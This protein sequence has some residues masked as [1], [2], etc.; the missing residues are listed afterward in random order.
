MTD[1]HA[2]TLA[3]VREQDDGFCLALESIAD[4]PRSLFDLPPSREPTAGEIS[5]VRRAVGAIVAHERRPAREVN[6][7]RWHTR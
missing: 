2:Q 1:L 7:L 4:M 3:E 5:A 6:G